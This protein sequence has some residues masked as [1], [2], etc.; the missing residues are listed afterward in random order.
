MRSVAKFG[1]L[2]LVLPAVCAAAALGCTRTPAPT[3]D[4][5]TAPINESLPAVAPAITD[6]AAIAPATEGAA[7]DSSAQ[8][9]STQAAAPQTHTA[10]KPVVAEYA[11]GVPPVLLSAAHGQLCKVGVGDVLPTIELPK[12]DGSR[13]T[14]ESLA[15]A[16]ATVVVFWTG[17]RWMSETALRDLARMKSSGDVGMVGIASGV[18]ADAMQKMVAATAAKF[19][20]LVDA[21]GTALA[22]VGQNSLPRI[23]VLDSQRRIAW[24]DIEYSESSRR[25]IQQ[26]LAVLTGAGS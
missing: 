20:Q 21:E 4:R 10:A 11:P 24:F 8:A 3:S 25:E 15:G 16:K 22:Q 23:Y 2:N 14:L 13:A 1:R 12:T 19:P 17:D 9:A 26:T 5:A 6:V 7:D 18:G